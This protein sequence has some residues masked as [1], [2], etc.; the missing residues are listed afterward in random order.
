MYEIKREPEDFVVEEITPD[1]KVI[2]AGGT[3]S[4]DEK[5]EGEQ[6]VCALQKR[7]WDTNLAIRAVAERLH[8]S[9]NRIGFAGTKD[10]R[11]VSA[12]RISI[13]GAKPEDIA[14]VRLRDISVQALGRSKD[15]IELGDL[16]GNRFTIKVY[17]EKKLG[18]IP[19]KI[20]NYFGVQRFGETRPLTDE[21]GELVVKGDLQG[22]VKTYL[23]KIFPGES[24][25]SKE[26][27]ARLAKDW[28]YREALKYF[29]MTL[30]F[31]RTL[32][33]HLAE[34]PNDYAGALRKLPKFLKIMFVHALQSRLFNRFLDEAIK[35][36]K[37]LKEGPLYGYELK[38]KNQLEK[39]VLKKSGFRLDEFFVRWMPEMSS[40]GERRALSVELKDFEVLEKGEGSCVLRFS[41]PR[42]CY[43][44]TVIDYLFCDRKASSSRARSSVKTL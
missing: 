9:K 5:S 17:S 2:E 36:K 35:Q 13:W 14:R 27:R 16:W 19:K 24:D 30:G 28:D 11:A 1:G 21:I 6:L 38:L 25:E 40:K 23:A 32:I 20:P 34:H 12:Q 29:P 33:G 44:T 41:L 15:R 8:V 39:D 4:F 10:K 31:E 7:N 22:A 18:K 26:A 43:A 3:H 37:K 42:G